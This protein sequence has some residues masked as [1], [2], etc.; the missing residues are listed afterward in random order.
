MGRE[1]CQCP[2]GERRLAPKRGNQN[3]YNLRVI[4]D[5]DRR[6]SGTVP[7]L[8]KLLNVPLLMLV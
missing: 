4:Q 7:F 1:H 5:A 8:F 2:L 3:N 6:E